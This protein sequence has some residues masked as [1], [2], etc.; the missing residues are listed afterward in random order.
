[1]PYIRRFN[2]TELPPSDHDYIDIFNASLSLFLENAWLLNTIYYTIPTISKKGKKKIKCEK[3]LFS[4][5][6][7]S[8]SSI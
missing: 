3:C 7:V 8:N 5:E 1:M 2:L 4:L 6:Y